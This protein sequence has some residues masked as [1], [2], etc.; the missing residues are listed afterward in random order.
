MKKEKNDY[1][2]DGVPGAGKYL[3]DGTY[4]TQV[5]YHGESA[6]KARGMKSESGRHCLDIQRFGKHIYAQW[7]Y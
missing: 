6:I 5:G 1:V 7:N 4:W 3:V 2:D